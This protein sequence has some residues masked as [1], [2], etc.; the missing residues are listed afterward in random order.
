MPPTATAAATIFALFAAILAC[1][2]AG[3]RLRIR[4]TPPGSYRQFEGLGAL[5]GAIFG[6]MGLL[7]AFTFSGAAA[8]FD[9]RRQLI[10]EECNAI[11]TAYLRVDLLPP[12]SQPPLRQAFRAY[13]EARYAYYQALP[14][15]AAARQA[16]ARFTGLQQEIWI[17]AVAASRDGAPPAAAILLLPALNQMIDLASTRSAARQIHPSA[18]IFWML[19]A[20][21]IAASL[22]AGW[23]MAA[24]ARRSWLHLGGFALL[25]TLAIYVIL[26]LE[27]PRLGLIR[28]DAFDH[29][30]LDVRASMK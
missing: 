16:E 1:L 4:N 11:G 25:M 29:Y 15:A 9:T 22:L 14:E 20:A 6:L 19:G 2:E 18:V 5:E 17:G 28:V 26:D 13:S 3:Y 7:V 30:L 23:G 21:V 24:G 12:A 10:V 8:R 27:Y